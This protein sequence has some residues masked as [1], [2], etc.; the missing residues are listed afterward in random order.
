MLTLYICMVRLCLKPSLQDT[1]DV[2]MIKSKMY[3]NGLPSTSGMPTFSAVAHV[4]FFHSKR[5]VPLDLCILWFK[6]S[7]EVDGPL[8]SQ[9][10][11]TWGKPQSDMFISETE[12]IKPLCDWGRPFRLDGFVRMGFHLCVSR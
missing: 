3:P 2:P 9:D 8:D 11:V 6:R 4:M 10:I 5:K 12:R 7:Q 1:M